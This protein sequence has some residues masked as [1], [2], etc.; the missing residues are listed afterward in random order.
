MAGGNIMYFHQLLDLARADKLKEFDRLIAVVHE[1]VASLSA[2]PVPVV[3][4]VC[5]AVAGFGLSL[6]AGCD[7]AYATKSSFFTSAY[8]LLGMSPDGGSSFFIPRSVGFKKSME[9]VL[10]TKRYS[11]KEAL[12][13]GLINEIV[14][15]EY[16]DTEVA[17]FAEQIANSSFGAVRNAKRLLRQ[18]FETELQTQLELEY[19]SFLECVVSEDF[20]EGINAFVEKRSPRFNC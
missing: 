16:L 10:A 15:D 17:K 6:V 19:D 20:A 1:L 18:S 13:M 12:K 14:A 11:V 2:L 9:I 4:K 8:N 5:G 7:L 3:A